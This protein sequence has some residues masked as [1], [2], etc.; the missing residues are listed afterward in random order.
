MKRTKKTL[1]FIAVLAAT[2]VATSGYAMDFGA[3]YDALFFNSRALRLEDAPELKKNGFRRIIT[4]ITVGDE[5]FL[6]WCAAN[7]T[8]V[9]FTRNALTNAQETAYFTKYASTIDS[10]QVVDDADLTPGGK[11]VVVAAVN[12]AK[13]RLPATI[14]T[15]LPFTKGAKP[16][17]WANI[18]DIV[19][20]ELYIH[21][22]GTIRK[23]YWDYVLAWRKAHAGKLVVLPYLG[24]RVPPHFG[25]YPRNAAGQLLAPD[26][27]WSAK[28]YT[29]LA[30]NEA[31]IWAALCA[32]A[33]DIWYYSAYSIS[34]LVAESEYRIAKR[35][36]LLPGYGMLHE[37]IRSYERFFAGK[38]EPFDEGRYVG[39]VWTLPTGETLTVRV[40]TYETKPDVTFSITKTQATVTPTANGFKVEFN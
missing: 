5:P 32:G 1:Q 29:P 30:Y 38:R 31:A 9:T 39:A 4:P 23:Y 28:E 11:A 3:Y 20:L 22:E 21:G 16:E 7:D 34:N 12:A 25:L 36:D 27:V 10:Y 33:D 19:G 37:Q 18:S 2:L 14:K 8:K 13:A 17:D 40:D 15:Y 26:P 24:K 6:D 35:W